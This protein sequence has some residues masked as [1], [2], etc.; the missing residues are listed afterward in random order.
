MAVG[1]SAF[2]EHIAANAADPP[3]PE[4]L[5]VNP[6]RLEQPEPSADFVEVFESLRG[7][8]LPTHQARFAVN[9][10]Y[11]RGD[12]FHFA[13]PSV[14]AA[15][16]N[17]YADG[18]K[19]SPKAVK[20]TQHDGYHLMQDDHPVLCP[21]LELPTWPPKASVYGGPCWGTLGETPRSPYFEMRLPPYVPPQKAGDYKPSCTLKSLT[22]KASAACEWYRG[23]SVN[24][25][26]VMDQQNMSDCGAA[27][28]RRADLE[29]LDGG[30]SSAL[31][32]ALTIASL[33]HFMLPS[34]AAGVRAVNPHGAEER[35]IL[36]TEFEEVRSSL[37]PNEN[38]PRTP[39]TLR[40]DLTCVCRSLDTN[41]IQPTMRSRSR[42]SVASAAALRFPP[43]AMEHLACCVAEASSGRKHRAATSRAGGSSLSARSGRTS[44]PA[45]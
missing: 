44:A 23:A 18:T 38:P 31:K 21:T 13:K 34:F 42:T 6:I 40:T 19:A 10:P 35:D 39:R 25:M 12:R 20:L 1:C 30:A 29:R 2:R 32:K 3:E 11:R 27:N 45:C 14:K 16:D 33:H 5:Q 41:C 17:Y 24:N 4:N 8:G 15:F 36:Q 26:F 22:G 43:T 37:L 9:S 28:N 7:Q